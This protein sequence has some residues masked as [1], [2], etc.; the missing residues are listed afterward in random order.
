MANTIEKDCQ[1]MYFDF[2]LPTTR[3]RAKTEEGHRDQE[4]KRERERERGGER[5]KRIQKIQNK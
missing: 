4:R 5:E 1:D 2:T 3:R